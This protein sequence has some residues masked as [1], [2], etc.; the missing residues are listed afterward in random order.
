[1]NKKITKIV[2]I[3]VLVLIAAVFIILLIPKTEE[4][5]GKM[6]I[7]VTTFSS[8]DFVKHIV[9]DKANVIFLLGPGVDSHSYE[10]SVKEIEKIR[11][12]DMFIYIGGEMEKWTDG[13]LKTDVIGDNTRIIKISE[14]VETIDEQEVDGAEEEEED[15]EGAFDEHIWTSPANAIKMMEYLNEA[16]CKMDEE[17]REFYTKNTNEYNT[18]I[19]DV[20][21]KIQNIVDHRVRNRLVFADKMPMQ[22]FLNEYGLTASA[23]FSGCST[24]TEPGQQTVLYLINKVKEEQ[25]PVVLY[26]ELGTGQMASS[27]AHEAGAEVMQIQ[28]LHNIS[29][30]D[31]D[32]GETY[33]SLMTR[34]IEVLKKALQ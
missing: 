34:N 30:T 9:G 18:Q 3:L 17:N 21:A 2:L 16:I 31:F 10:P 22:Y 14:S 33:V 27:I 15:V 25:I 12:A 4:D 11:K 28:T 6:N 26:I 1:M 13:V 23:A 32:N 19:K 8:Y 20:Q 24:E 29:K 5:N 7:V